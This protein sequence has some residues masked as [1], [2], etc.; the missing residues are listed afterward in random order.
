MRCEKYSKQKKE[1]SK[2]WQGD[3]EYEM[4]IAWNLFGIPSSYLKDWVNK[5]MNIEALLV[6]SV[7]SRHR[8]VSKYF[9]KTCSKNS[10]WFHGQNRLKLQVQ[11]S[12]GLSRKLSVNKLANR[13]VRRF[14]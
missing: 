3:F 10:E 6:D 11:F 1:I 7:W 8:F 2:Y 5:L 4:N 14:R 12:L 13:E 9:L